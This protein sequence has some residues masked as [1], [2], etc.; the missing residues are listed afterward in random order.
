MSKTIIS[1]VLRLIAFALSALPKAV[2]SILAL[3]DLV[4]DGCINNSVVRPDWI[5]DLLDVVEQING[6]GSTLTQIQNKVRETPT[7]D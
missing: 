7:I 5:T 1:L 4:D 2:N 6:V 3:I